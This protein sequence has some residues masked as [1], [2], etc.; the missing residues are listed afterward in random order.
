L[1]A[2]CDLSLIPRALGVSA[3]R[4]LA[5]KLKRANRRAREEMSQ[6]YNALE[7]TFQGIK[8]VKAS[9]WNVTSGGDSTALPRI[10][11]VKS[12]RIAYFSIPLTRRSRTAGNLTHLRG[13]A[14]GAY[15]AMRGQ[16]HLFGS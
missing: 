2:C 13:H 7:E 10:Y 8:I 16:T 5:R 14:A 11:Y 4:W 6:I 9:R 3:H 15:L 12:M 1:L